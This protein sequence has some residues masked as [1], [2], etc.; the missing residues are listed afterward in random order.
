MSSPSR[1]EELARGA[2][3][4]ACPYCSVVLDPPPQR[5][6]RCPAC[7]ESITVRTR[8]RRKLYFTEE[9]AQAYDQARVAEIARNKAIRAAGM[10]GVDRDAFERVEQEMEGWLPGDVFWAIAGRRAAECARSG[11]Y[12]GLGLAYFQQALWL[13]DEGR[14]WWGLKSEAEKAFARAYAAEG[15]ERLVL[16][17]GC[18]EA[19]DRYEGREYSARE[20]AECWPIPEGTCTADWC[21]CGW[22]GRPRAGSLYQPS[23]GLDEDIAAAIRESRGAPEEAE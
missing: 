2:Q 20:A 23:E 10:L 15:Y 1:A 9:G 19:C 18:C 17:T 13:K 21:V 6:R 16:R 3:A 11:D 22:T 4:P 7:R 14:S 8:S 5:T 12:R